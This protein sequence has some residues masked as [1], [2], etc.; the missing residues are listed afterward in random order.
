MSF[1]NFLLLSPP[2]LL[3]TVILVLFDYCASVFSRLL[4]QPHYF[5][6]FRTLSIKHNIILSAHLLHTIIS[7]IYK[8]DRL[9]P[10]KDQEKLVGVHPPK[11]THCRLLYKTN[12]FI[13]PLIYITASFTFFSTHCLFS[14]VCF[15]R[16]E[17]AQFFS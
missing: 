14:F 3:T 4:S 16:P 11:I 2:S 13:Y 1:I 15:G 17:V 10:K 12:I 5:L 9:F 6:L 7:V 8:A